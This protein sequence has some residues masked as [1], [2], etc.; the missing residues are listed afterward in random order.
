LNQESPVPLCEW[1]AEEKKR[2]EGNRSQKKTKQISKKGCAHV[3]ESRRLCSKVA[4]VNCLEREGVKG[5]WRD[6]CLESRAMHCGHCSRC[7]FY[8]FS[9]SCHAHAHIRIHAYSLEILD[10]RHERKQE[11]K[12]TN[13]QIW[14]HSLAA[15]RA[16]D[17][18][19]GCE[20]SG[21]RGRGPSG[22][23]VSAGPP[24]VPARPGRQALVRCP[25]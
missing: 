8:S 4:G 11:D 9:A 15:P 24:Q 14:W 10:W 23:G 13:R 25:G 3:R 18:G 1:R 5:G 16:R 21:R 2:R 17:S 22:G 12:Q 7:R 19:G 20:G 6:S